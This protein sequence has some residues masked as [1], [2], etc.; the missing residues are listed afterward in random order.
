MLEMAVL[1]QGAAQHCPNSP[2]NGSSRPLEWGGGGEGA[3]FSKMKLG[4]GL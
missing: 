2:T 1:W 3:E 4:K